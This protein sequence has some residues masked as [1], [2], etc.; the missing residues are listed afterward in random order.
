MPICFLDVPA[1]IRTDAKQ[2]LVQ[3]ATDALNETFQG[4]DVRI[5]FREYQAENAAQDGRIQAEPVRPVC[6]L[7]VPPLRN[8]DAKRGLTEKLQAAF[9]DAYEGIANTDQFVIF[10]NHYP[11]EDAALGGSLFSDKQQAVEVGR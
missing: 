5:F 1:G 10:Y 3:K 4:P 9:G 8:L 6:T 11:P 2:K 7:N